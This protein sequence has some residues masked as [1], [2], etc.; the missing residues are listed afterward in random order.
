MRKILVPVAAT[1]AAAGGAAALYLGL[2]DAE[3]HTAIESGKTL[4]QV[5][6][7]KGKSVS[8]LVDALVKEAKDHLA[9]E[10]TEGR[11]TQAQADQMLTDA[12]AKI[13]DMVNNGI[14]RPGF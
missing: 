4:A 3:L 10:V 11:L 7:D 9:T 2:T 5:A 14:R 6:K 1:A 8:G 12:K 13:T